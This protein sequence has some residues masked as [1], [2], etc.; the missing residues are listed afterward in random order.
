H[1]LHGGERSIEVS[2]RHAGTRVGELRQ[3]EIGRHLRA[4]LQLSR[5]SRGLQ[6]VI[7]EVRAGHGVQDRRA[8][9]AERRFR[10]DD[11]AGGTRV[12]PEAMPDAGDEVDRGRVA[13][14]VAAPRIHHDLLR[15][16]AARSAARSGEQCE[17]GAC[18]RDQR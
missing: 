15:R 3:S 4:A 5:Q 10:R 8:R 17:Q 2:A 9:R 7:D 6:G 1:Q 14:L 12:E 11:A 18:A 16:D 13:E